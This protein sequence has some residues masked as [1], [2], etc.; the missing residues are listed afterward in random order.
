MLSVFVLVALWNLSIESKVLAQWTQKEGPFWETLAEIRQ[1]NLNIQ[2]RFYQFLTSL[3]PIK[4]EPGPIR[5]VYID[6]DVHWTNLY[7]DLPTNRGFLAKLLYNASQPTTKAL[8]IGLDVELLAPRS[9]PPGTDAEER[10]SD[11]AKLKEALYFASRNG[12]P[13]VLT[14]TYRVEVTDNQKRNVRLPNIFTDEELPLQKDGRCPELPVQSHGFVAQNH[15]PYPGCVWFGYINAPDDKREIAL[16]EQLLDPVSG[17]NMEYDSF[18]LALAKAAE[19]SPA[20]YDGDAFKDRA[21]FGSFINEDKFGTVSAMALANGNDDAKRACWGK[22]LL[23]GGNW[24]DLQGYGRRVDAHLSPVGIISG[25]AFHANYVAALMQRQFA[26]EVPTWVGILFDL[27]VGLVIYVTF[28]IAMGWQK[29]VVLAA[30]ALIPPAIAYV[31]LVT[32]NQYLD[33]LLPVELYFLHIAYEMATEYW[34]I[35]SVH[36]SHA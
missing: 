26:T 36:K 35:K 23:I 22:I 11:N 29:L 30:A 8:A 2:L 25:V 24:R 32:S 28:E 21:I 19:G 9:F 5:I 6:D 12:V 1:V 7:G 14:T 3:R 31:F 16:S 18:A 27:L 13:V 33:F 17:K 10:A 34:G 20:E 15:N 4:M